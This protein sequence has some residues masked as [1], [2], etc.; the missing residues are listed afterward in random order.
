MKKLHKNAEKSRR[1]AENW[2]KAKRNLPSLNLMFTFFD[3][4]LENGG[5]LA[6]GVLRNR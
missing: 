5:N 6:A 2:R 1:M 3:E 4:F